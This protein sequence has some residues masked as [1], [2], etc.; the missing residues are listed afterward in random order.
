MFILVVD[1]YASSVL[2]VFLCVCPFFCLFFSQTPS[3]RVNKACVK[4][5]KITKTIN[6]NWWPDLF[7]TVQVTK[8][9]KAGFFCFS[10]VQKTLR[11]SQ[12]QEISAP[13][14][15]FEYE[16][17]RFNAT[18]SEKVEFHFLSLV[19]FVLFCGRFL[20]LLRFF[21]HFKAA[22]RAWNE[23]VGVSEIRKKTSKACKRLLRSFVML[24]RKFLGKSLSL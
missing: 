15:Y 4:R 13:F 7:E 6:E 14:T 1:R 18:I 12:V 17:Q 21:G 5:G 8:W 10:K 2:F 23:R 20:N 9:L 16:G 11:Q 24:W 3:P 22:L 19:C